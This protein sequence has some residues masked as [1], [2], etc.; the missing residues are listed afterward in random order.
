[1]DE[2]GVF[3]VIQGGEALAGSVAQACREAFPGAKIFLSPAGE[4]P[5]SWR[6]I[7]RIPPETCGEAAWGDV[8]QLMAEAMSSVDA[9]AANPPLDCA[10]ES[11]EE[12]FR[13]LAAFTAD[14]PGSAILAAP[15]GEEPVP[16]A[17]A[18]AS[19]FAWKMLEQP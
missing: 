9:N 8:A 14:H 15:A 11:F 12:L 4:H 17:R 18:S 1:M 6:V 13:A 16:L 5:P 2:S 10:R 7:A 3:F 19:R